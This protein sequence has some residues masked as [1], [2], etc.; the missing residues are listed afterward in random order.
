MYSAWETVKVDSA[1]E[2]EQERQVNDS[3]NEVKHPQTDTN[4]P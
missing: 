2:G 4:A 3:P 1:N